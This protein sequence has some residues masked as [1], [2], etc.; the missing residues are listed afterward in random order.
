LI[1]LPV[2]RQRHAHLADNCIAVCKISFRVF[3][4][5][6]L[7]IDSRDCP[8]EGVAIA[9]S[10]Q[11]FAPQ[12]RHASWESSSYILMA[13]SPLDQLQFIVHSHRTIDIFSEQS[14]PPHNSD[15]LDT[16]SKPFPTFASKTNIHNAWAN[17]SGD[18]LRH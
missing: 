7:V 14:N 8:Q 10:F 16:V 11:I 18:H 4:R 6:H 15:I 2:G 13:P 1:V 12:P 17:C 5:A 3:S 9:L